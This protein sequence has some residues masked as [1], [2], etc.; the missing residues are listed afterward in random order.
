MNKYT[1]ILVDSEHVEIHADGVHVSSGCLVFYDEYK[2]NE[3]D[4][5]PDA[6]ST[7]IMAA[8]TW[9]FCQLEDKE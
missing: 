8:G 3:E 7:H 6:K 2:R 9:V 5:Y 1:V 4:E